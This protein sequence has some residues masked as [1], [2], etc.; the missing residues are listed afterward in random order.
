LPKLVWIWWWPEVPSIK[1]PRGSLQ[2][3]HRSQ[4]YAPGWPWHKIK[5]LL[6]YSTV[7]PHLILI[8]CRLQVR[9]IA[10]SLQWAYNK[11]I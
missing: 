10:C 1:E 7:L 4:Q 11:T 6:P 3:D 2:G 8:D 9:V 5:C